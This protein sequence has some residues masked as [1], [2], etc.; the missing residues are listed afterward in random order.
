[1]GFVRVEGEGGRQGCDGIIFGGP[2][3]RDG[4][5]LIAH[6]GIKRSVEGQVGQGQVA[7]WGLIELQMER[8]R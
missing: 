6:A 5:Y 1:M 7:W 3:E 4:A 8:L 2:L